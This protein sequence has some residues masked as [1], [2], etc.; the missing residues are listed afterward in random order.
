MGTY[1]LFSD[2]EKLGDLDRCLFLLPTKEQE[3]RYA[4]ALLSADLRPLVRD[5]DVERCEFSTDFLR[6]VLRSSRSRPSSGS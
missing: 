6:R 5:P 3:S 2:R 4:K 1:I